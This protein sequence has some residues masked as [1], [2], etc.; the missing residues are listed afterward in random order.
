MAGDNQWAAVA[1]ASEG[2]L[3]LCTVLTVHEEGRGFTVQTTARLAAWG[4]SFAFHPQLAANRQPRLPRIAPRTTATRTLVQGCVMLSL[5]CH[6][7][8]QCDA[9]DRRNAEKMAKTHPRLLA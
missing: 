3:S 2:C 9:I 5:C 8:S 6:T 4:R 7:Q 1:T